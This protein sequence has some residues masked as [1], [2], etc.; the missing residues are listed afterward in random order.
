MPNSL[1]SES[2]ASAVNP[3]RFFVG[4]VLGI[5]SRIALTIGLVVGVEDVEELREDVEEDRFLTSLWLCRISST[6]SK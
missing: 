2:F 6:A 3:R 4:G 5:V 1:D